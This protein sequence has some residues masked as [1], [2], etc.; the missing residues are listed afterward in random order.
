MLTIKALFENGHSTVY[1]KHLGGAIYV[2]K[3]PVERFIRFRKYVKT[4]MSYNN[5][6]PPV[7]ASGFNKLGVTLGYSEFI[8]L[9]QSIGT[10]EDLSDEFKQARACYESEW[11]ESYMGLGYYSCSECAPFY[12]GDFI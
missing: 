6:D 10:I 11:H 12:T 3:S 4:D 5:W 2:S 8:R 7:P 1:E 9:I